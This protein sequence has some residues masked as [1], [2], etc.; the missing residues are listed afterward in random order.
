M[1]IANKKTFLNQDKNQFELKLDNYSAFIAFK[2]MKNSND[3]YMTH[4]E[5]PEALEGKGIGNKLVR[6]SLDIVGN[7]GFLVVPLCPFVRYFIF[8]NLKDYKNILSPKTKM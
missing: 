3:V 7:E 1:E 2:R 6:E 8:S 4:T 5:V